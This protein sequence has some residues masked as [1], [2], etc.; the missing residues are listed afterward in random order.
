MNTN[1]MAIYVMAYTFEDTVLNAWIRY[2]ARCQPF[3]I[4]DAGITILFDKD[5]AEFY[6]NNGW[7]K[8]VTR[9]YLERMEKC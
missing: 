6:W 1:D 8:L 5:E 7:E 2:C 4:F 9:I 3:E